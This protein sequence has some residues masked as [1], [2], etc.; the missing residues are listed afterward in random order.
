MWE[1]ATV[2]ATAQH[3]PGATFEC[4]ENAGHFPPLSAPKSFTNR[5]RAFLDSMAV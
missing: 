3:L 4:I 5:V 2:E 1:P